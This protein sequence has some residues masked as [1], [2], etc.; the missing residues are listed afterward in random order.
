[1]LSLWSGRKKFEIGRFLH[2]KSETEKLKLDLRRIGRQ[3]NFKFLP[4]F[5]NHAPFVV[6]PSLDPYGNRENRDARI[7]HHMLG[8]R[9]KQSPVEKAP[10]LNGQKNQ[11]CRTLGRGFEDPLRGRTVVNRRLHGYTLLS[12]FRDEQIESTVRFSS[13]EVFCLDR[14]TEFSR[15]H[16]G[17]AH[18]VHRY[19]VRPKSSCGVQG[20]IEGGSGRF[21][22]VRRKEDPF[23][24]LWSSD[25]RNSQ[26]GNMKLSQ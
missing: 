24:G 5:L 22:Q 1:L 17:A 3:S 4:F 23:D 25:M 7:A 8:G 20:E 16:H 19:K 12:A 9:S 21:G 15:S 11:V 2:F 10:G 26:H 14:H 18:S 13:G 6:C